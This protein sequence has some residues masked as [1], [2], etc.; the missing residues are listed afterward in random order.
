MAIIV[1][2]VIMQFDSIKKYLSEFRWYRDVVNITPF[3]GETL[4]TS[5]ISDEGIYL[6]GELIKRRCTFDALIGYVTFNDKPKL[7][8]VITSNSNG[9][10]RPP[11]KDAESWGPWLLEY[12][13]DKE[14]NGWQIYVDHVKCPTDPKRQTNLFLEGQWKD[15]P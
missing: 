15:I 3:Y 7:R 8:V 9:G 4:H 1:F 14:P 12:S 10:S 5:V 6:R 13:G 11:S 2:S